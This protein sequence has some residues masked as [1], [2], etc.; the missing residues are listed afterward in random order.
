MNMA[1]IIIMIIIIIIVKRTLPI[2]F[3]FEYFTSCQTVMA[4]QPSDNPIKKS[5]SYT[6][7]NPV[8]IVQPSD[9]PIKTTHSTNFVVRLF[10]HSDLSNEVL[11]QLLLYG[12]EKFSYDLDETP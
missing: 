5:L 2:S 8:R 6:N 7:P 9:K 11:T 4:F 12:D 10:G 1:F 3:K